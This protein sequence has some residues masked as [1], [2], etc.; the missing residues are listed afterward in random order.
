MSQ[1]Y[2]TIVADPPWEQGRTSNFKHGVG[3]PAGPNFEPDTEAPAA[4]G[5]LPYETMSLAEIE[6]LPVAEIAAADAH[7]YVWTTHKFLRATFG[8]AEAWGFRHSTTLV[9]VKKPLGL[10]LGGA[11]PST[12]EF[13]LFC[14]RGKLAPIGRAEKEWWE[15]PRKRGAP[16]KRGE[17]RTEGHSAKPDAFIDIVEQV[18]PGPYLEMFARRER[19]G[20]RTWGNDSLGTAELPGAAA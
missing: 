18:S 17:R 10:K 7:L 11:F 3:L 19:L 15:W 12:V 16:V 4:R 6:A 5:E 8:V 9:W 20:W 2:R 1:R 13:C 14:T